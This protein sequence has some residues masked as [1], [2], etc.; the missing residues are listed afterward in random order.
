MM[1]SHSLQCND[2]V[3]LMLNEIQHHIVGQLLWFAVGLLFHTNIQVHTFLF[4]SP[5]L[6]ALMIAFRLPRP[7]QTRC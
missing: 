6:L 1:Q 5:F 7:F 2:K 3:V 4:S